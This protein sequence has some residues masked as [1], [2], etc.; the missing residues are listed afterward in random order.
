[1]THLLRLWLCT[2]V[3]TNFTSVFDSL[4]IAKVWG[5]GI[6]MPFL[7]IFHLTAVT[8]SNC[9]DI[10]VVYTLE[11]LCNF[12]KKRL[13]EF[14]KYLNCN[15]HIE[16]CD[17]YKD[18]V[19]ETTTDLDEKIFIENYFKDTYREKT[20]SKKNSALTK[21]TNIDIWVIGTSNQ[22]FIRGS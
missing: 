19:S 1:M 11:Y 4:S 17:N 21:S 9:L 12:Y 15:I 3:A 5:L 16:L 6:K 10:A 14:Y 13:H 8:V 7:T 20:P 18:C 2:D 22:L